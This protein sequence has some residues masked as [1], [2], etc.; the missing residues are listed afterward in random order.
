MGGLSPNARAWLASASSAVLLFLAFLP[1]A[2]AWA[3]FTW[4]VPLA[5]W[6][7]T[8]PDPVL[9]RRA[10]AAASLLTWVALLAWLRHVHP[11]L[12]WLGWTLLSA[13][14]AAYLWV[15]CLAL[16][17]ILTWSSGRPLVDRLLAIL[18]AAALWVL[19]EA[20]RGWALTGFGWLP[21]A[22]SQ[23]G[24][25]VMLAL[26]EVAGPLGLSGALVLANLALARWIRRQFAEARP[27]AGGKASLLGGFTPELYLGLAPVVAAFWLHLS[28]LADAAAEEAAGRGSTLRV[29]VVQTDVD[30]YRKWDPSSANRLTA[31]LFALS[32]SLDLGGTDLILW[33]EAAAPYPLSDPSY[34]GFLAAVARASNATLVIGA[35][36]RRERGYANSIAAIGPEG[37]L[38]AAYDKRR[39]V[40]FGEYVP[41]A[42]F[43][44]LRKLVPI[45]EDCVPGEAARLLAVPD[46]AGRPV[47]LGP[48]VCYEDIF[49]S[50]ARDH[51]LAS[52]Q[53]L[54]VLTND[55]WYGRE[56]GAWQHAAHSVLLAASTRLPVV[57]CGN[58]G[59]SGWIEP[60]GRAFPALREGSIYFGGATHLGERRLPAPERPATRWTSVGDAPLLLPCVLLLVLL[61]I[62]RRRHPLGGTAPGAGD[63]T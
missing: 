40:P 53:G 30:P 56:L 44:P 31:E 33:P 23:A 17:P 24:N 20:L 59:W 50:L 12:G 9:W 47:L 32:T 2:F 13:Y 8:G 55:A 48:L 21:L 60:S 39:L 34:G 25:P 61:A 36:D 38:G 4:A 37:Q 7:M 29:A 5:L 63:A 11:P 35:I 52:A 57:R 43:L 46:A 3:G 26:C 10:T 6:A 45:P 49:P 14:C 18:G 19:L 58:A 54:V 42:G 1:G 28:H 22:A 27:T 41:L 62:R 15:W 51:A 16:R